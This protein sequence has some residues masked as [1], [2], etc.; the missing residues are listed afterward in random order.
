MNAQTN[1]PVVQH[2]WN[3]AIEAA[4]AKFKQST[5]DFKQEQIFAVQLLI[6]N[7]YAMKVA[8]ENP[9]SLKLAMYNVAAVGLSLNPS[10]GLAYLVPRRVNRNEPPRICLD[11]SY[12]G[13]IAVGVDVG[14]ILW[15]KSELVYEKD[16]FQ[17]KGP[18]EKPA[19]IADPFD[20][21]RGALRGAYCLAELPNGG[22]LVETMSIKE[23]N[24]I[25]DRSEAYKNGVGPWVDWE[26]QMRLKT[27]VKRAS[28]WWPQA[29]A[30]PRLGSAINVLNDENGEGIVFNNNYEPQQNEPV[31]PTLEQLPPPPK[32]EDVSGE[33]RQMVK[34][35]VD[36]A[37]QSQS[38]EACREVFGQR[39]GDQGE[40]AFALN[41]LKKAQDSAGQAATTH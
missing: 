19:H 14:S 25:R 31:A 1:Q 26:E 40:L 2:D 9:E 16:Q 27:V 38:F 15:A 30:N 17:Y 28:K 23:M 39:I 6:N 11:I 3:Q 29:Q 10:Q 37:V 8:R 34:R 4:Q 35:F 7:P 41:E 21:D 12:R 18:A 24:K 33:L 36:R 32:A 13:L 22:F 5:L 20:D